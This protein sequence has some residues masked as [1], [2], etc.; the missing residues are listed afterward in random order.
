MDPVD[1]IEI[2]G[3]LLVLT[4]FAAAQRGRLDVRSPR[5][6][7]LNLVGSAV[8]AVIALAHASWGFLLL[9]GVWAI[10]SAVSLVGVLRGGG[11]APGDRPH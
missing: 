10:V 9:E 4:A 6:L 11:R 3:S 5:Y 8:L 2:G 1:L 7:L